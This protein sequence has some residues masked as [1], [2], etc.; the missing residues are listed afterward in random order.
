MTYPDRKYGYRYAETAEASTTEIARRIRVDIAQAVAE[1]LLPG[2]PVT[3]SVTSEYYSGGSS[4][5]VEVKGWPEAWVPC[6]GTK[7][8]SRRTYPDGSLVAIACPNFWCKA[9]EDR[10][11]AADHDVLT[12]EAEVAMLTLRRIHDAYNHD[13]SDSMVDYYDVNYYGG[14]A[15][16]SRSSA[17]SEAAEKARLKARRQALNDAEAAGT[18]RV[19]NYSRDGKSQVHDAVE[20]DGKSHLVCGAA[21]RGGGWASQAGDQPLTCSRCIKRAAKRQGV[22]A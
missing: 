2:K 12:V 5:D 13:G 19:V 14:V 22:R 3:Y 11:S 8:G 6:D 9:R 1:G 21:L 18:V 17:E 15:I 16:Q 7:P 10:P 4:I 20:V